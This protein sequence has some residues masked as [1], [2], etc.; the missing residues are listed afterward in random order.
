MQQHQNDDNTIILH[1]LQR[2]D[3]Q[4]SSMA[5][6]N[7]SSASFISALVLF[8]GKVDIKLVATLLPDQQSPL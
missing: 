3:V 4:P 6:I 2:R 8:Q 1:Y 5:N 7:N